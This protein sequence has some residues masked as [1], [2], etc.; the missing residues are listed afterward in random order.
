MEIHIG[1]KNIKDSND[2]LRCLWAE[3]SKEFG[4][5]AW[6]YAPHKQLNKNG[7]F[8][9]FMD[10]GV[11]SEL[12]VS[13]TYEKKGTIKNLYFELEGE[14]QTIPKSMELHHRIKK[15]VKIAKSK[16]G[17]YNT[18]QYA[19]VI[20]THRPLAS[21]KGNYFQ[22]KIVK[23]NLTKVEFQIQGYDSNQASGKATKKL[24]QIMDFLCVE[25]NAPFWEDKYINE[26]QKTLDKEIFQ[27][28]EDFIEG[29]PAINNYIVLSKEGKRILDKIICPD[30]QESAD[31]QLFLKA[32]NHFH[33]AR[34]YDSG[35]FNS[36][37]ED[38]LV[39][40]GNADFQDLDRELA[41]SRRRG[42][43]YTEIATTLYLS[44]L[45]VI[46]LT[47]LKEEKCN[48]CGQSK[49]QI[50]KRVKNLVSK[51]MNDSV[52][53]KLIDY[54]DK[55]SKYLHAG[56]QLINDEPTISSIPL[57]D[58][59]DKTGCKVPIQVSLLNLR[60]YVSYCLRKFYKENLLKS[61]G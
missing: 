26:P 19:P 16:V 2:F 23:E 43:S 5:C 49:F 24:K 59:E 40:K 44:A 39:V 42:D 47:N 46:T 31:L 33:T 55:R 53:K 17:N 30:K 48:C 36:I 14:L 27:V 18:F 34:K 6:I 32:C 10:I 57:L 35:L 22:T 52:A 37:E 38:Q 25:T 54:Y 28:D 8:F 21:Y 4:K 13:I 58:M 50:S 41:I 29:T 20:F 61:A 3:V 56:I 45:E 60:E 9:G 1:T 7:I 15:V 12:S 11:E 51:Y